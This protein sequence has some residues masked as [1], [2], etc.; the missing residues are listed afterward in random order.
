MG[1]GGAPDVDGTL[2]YGDAYYQGGQFSDTYPYDFGAGDRVVLTLDSPDFDTY[3]VV[4]S[5]S[6]REMV[7]DDSG[8]GNLNSRLEV[9]MSE[10]GTYQVVVTSYSVGATGRYHLH[11]DQP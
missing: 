4:R 2:A 9:V 1:G 8:F 7:N 10:S 11:V 6:G 3:L 5:P